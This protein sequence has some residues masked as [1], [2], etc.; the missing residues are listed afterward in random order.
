MWLSKLSRAQKTTMAAAIVIAAAVVVVGV[1]TQEEPDP[2]NQGSLSTNMS[3]AKIAPELG[4]TGKSLARDLELAIDVDKKASLREL[5]VSQK[6]LDNTIRHLAGHSESTV[7]YFIFGALVLLA[8]VYLVRLGR[9]DGS[10][11][12]DRKTWYPL[13]PYLLALLL[14]VVVCGFLLGKSPNPMEGAVKVFK[15][16]V[17]LYP[18]VLEKVLA[19]LFFIALAVVGTKLI[20][21]WACPFGALQELLYSLPVL[22]SLKKRKVPFAVSNTI[23]ILLFAAMLIVLTGLVGGKKGFVL[24]HYVNPFNLFNFD[25]ESLSV[26][27]TIA[28]AAVLS[29]GTYRPF[30]QFICPF[31]LLS[32]VLERLSLFGVRVDPDLCTQCGACI[33]ACPNEAAKGRV[34]HSLLAADCFSCGRCLNSCP[35]DAIR[36]GLPGRSTPKQAQEDQAQAC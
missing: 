3:I 8:W 14:A 32:W 36:Y 25:I 28:A 27:V 18:S 19:F 11:A 6:Q 4:V 29:L 20:C 21:G 26:G 23:R 2:M 17:G 13:W 5:G 16:M 35:V 12:S 15:S 30:C 24:Y 10:P 33:R 22:R 9:P 34:A 31:G 7:K 1:T